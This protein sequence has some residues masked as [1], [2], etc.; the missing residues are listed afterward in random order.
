MA[1]HRIAPM[2]VGAAGPPKPADDASLADF[3]RYA[4]LAEE[5]KF[6]HYLPFYWGPK[7]DTEEDRQWVRQM[8]D[9]WA[10]RG[11]LDKTYVYM[12]QFDEASADRWPDL[13]KYGKA[14]K[15]AEPRLQRMITLGPA[16]ELYGAVDIWCPTT[17]NYN[18][19]LAEQRRKVGEK[20]W[21]YNCGT[22][23]PGLVID[24]PGVEHRALVWLTWTQKADGLLYWCIDYWQKNPWDDPQMGS[25]TSGNGDGFFLYPRRPND[26]PDRLYESVRWEIL[27]DSIDDYEYF[28]TLRSRLDAASRNPKV[29]PEA[30]A[31]GRAA[32]GM[33]EK[34]AAGLR[35]YSLAP[36]D[37]AYVRHQIA[38]AIEGL[39]NPK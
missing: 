23:T 15:A 8:T 19:D 3:G 29:K 10:H 33:I 25:G 5:L 20:V 26:P 36:E 32:L 37:Y 24:R 35:A 4:D 11:V 1:Q 13:A 38:V 21:W 34:V 17:S 31:Q 22:I 2:H 39:P 12:C 16:P 28:W 27:R 9:W 14:L 7:V 30:I 18:F 6:S